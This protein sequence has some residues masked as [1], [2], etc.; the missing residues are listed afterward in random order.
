MLVYF[1]FLV[2]VGFRSWGCGRGFM[3]YTV[4][5]LT[6]WNDRF[7]FYFIIVIRYLCLF[8]PTPIKLRFIS[9]CLMLG[10]FLVFEVICWWFLGGIVVCEFC[11]FFEVGRSDMRIRGLVISFWLMSLVWV[12]WVLWI[13]VV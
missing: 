7:G 13:G 6:G 5:S 8:F 10:F 3:S 12:S 2:V 9:W 11:Y 4:L 1:V